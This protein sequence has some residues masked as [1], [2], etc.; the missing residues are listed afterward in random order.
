MRKGQKGGYKAANMNGRLARKDQKMDE[1][2]CVV[3]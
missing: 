3:M 1:T 2:E